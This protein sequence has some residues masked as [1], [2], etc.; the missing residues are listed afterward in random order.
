MDHSLSQIHQCGRPQSMQPQ[1]KSS[2]NRWWL[3]WCCSEARLRWLSHVVP[4]VSNIFSGQINLWPNKIQHRPC[5]NDNSLMNNTRQTGD[6]KYDSCEFLPFVVFSDQH[7]NECGDLCVMFL[8]FYERTELQ[9]F[10]CQALLKNLL[11]R[12]PISPQ[13][14]SLLFQG[15][16]PWTPGMC[17]LHQVQTR[18]NIL[19][20]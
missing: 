20:L 18:D 4:S 6:G 16:M 7:G 3:R 13:H 2:W 10:G 14:P 1:Q 5:L 9:N 19:D 15:W 17:C 12:N 11:Y 8:D